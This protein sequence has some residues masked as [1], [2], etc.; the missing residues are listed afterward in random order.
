M[1]T[2][3]AESTKC[4]QI[5]PS[6]CR[7]LRTALP[8]PCLQSPSALRGCSRRGCPGAQ[9][10]DGAARGCGSCE[11][12][13]KSDVDS[14]CGGEWLGADV[15][16]G[17]AG[18]KERERARERERDRERAVWSIQNQ[19]AGKRQMNTR[20]LQWQLKHGGG[21]GGGGGGGAG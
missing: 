15:G 8:A 6:A 1:E 18:M 12:H 3:S 16:K 11:M 13:S 17:G 20:T 9:M 10:K 14:G 21:G 4:E 2:P 19:S 7:L 5:A